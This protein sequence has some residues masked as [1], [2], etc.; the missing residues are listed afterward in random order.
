MCGIYGASSLAY[1]E[2]QYNQKLERTQFR[3][4][5][6]SGL[7]SI[8]LSPNQ[9]LTLGHNR[10]AIID[11][12]ARSNQPFQ[13]GAHL[14]I[15]FNGEIYNYREI[16]K[17]L[18]Q[19]GYAFST[20]S[21]TE[22]ICAA[23]LAHGEECVKFFNGMFAFVIYDEKKRVLFGA[24]DRL[25]QKPL[26]YFHK[27]VQFE[28]SS[29]ISS[30]AL[31]HD[32]LSISYESILN[33]LRWGYIPDPDSIYN[34]IKKLPAG[35][36]FVFDLT[37]GKYSENSY[38]NLDKEGN[39]TFSGSYGEAK[40]VLGDLIHDAVTKRMIADVPLGIFLSGGVDSSLVAAMAAKNN[41]EKVKTFSVK[42]NEKGFDES[43]YA[44][45]VASH[46]G[47]EH[48]TIECNYNE[49]LGLIDDFHLYYDEPFADSSA[50]PSM[51][52]SKY[53]RK[54]VTVALS[55]DGGDESFLGY[56]R[57]NWIRVAERFYKT[58]PFLRPL[59][60]SGLKNFPHYRTKVISKVLSS[61]N[62]EQAY[63]NMISSTDLSYIDTPSKNVEI[64]Y[65]DF[66]FHDGKNIYERASDFDLKTYL[67]GD[68]N[69]KVDRASMA[70]SLEARSPFLDYRV[71]EF[72]RSLP[73]EFKFKKNVQK[74][75]L[76]DLLYDY[77]PPQYFD[78]PKSG[79]T[80]PFKEWFR[81]DLREY[82]LDELSPNGLNSIPSIKVDEVSEMIQQHMDG[83]W[84]RYALIWKLLVLKQWLNKN[85]DGRE[86]H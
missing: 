19:R 70:F 80:M 67:N 52:L 42:F 44:L 1:S 33:Y 41:A 53:T 34:E 82:V 31:F 23:Y 4:P 8:S 16:K 38:W 43:D 85:A 12:E 59:I 10:L 17:D 68:I 22:V 69:T 49:G 26:Y 5:D 32:G 35:S 72:A 57:Y 71:V 29:Q 51:L 63:L 50:I 64:T 20:E 7:K 74:R 73:T 30:I 78:R 83:S 37:S 61:P 48:H 28:F 47:T 3:G 55:G 46:L 79:F 54:H 81:N 13:Y 66:L 6:Y 2:D 14:H 24:R 76:K 11:L 56:H 58:P 36:S 25:G 40:D 60:L 62:V 9:C 86:I 39:H 21:D 65:K 18:I 84:N 15:V 45:K 27:G 75:I 77:V